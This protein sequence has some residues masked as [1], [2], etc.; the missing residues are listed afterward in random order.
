MNQN[1]AEKPFKYETYLNFDE[2][3][4]LWMGGIGFVCE[5][6]SSLLC[7]SDINERDGISTALAMMMGHYTTTYFPDHKIKAAI[8]V[9]A[10]KRHLCVD[11]E[12]DKLLPPERFLF[13]G[14]CN[15]GLFAMEQMHTGQCESIPGMKDIFPT[16][17][18]DAIAERAEKFLEKMS[19]ITLAACAELSDEE[20]QER[21]EG[22][23][24]RR[25]MNP[26]FP[27]LSNLSNERTLH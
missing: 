2:E 7:P 6:I 19:L 8:D 1:T 16:G 9:A 15:F 5:V 27:Q 3:K 20:L 4:F 21:I 14:G 22:A 24:A 13:N 12:T 25:A 18:G 10:T 17:M 23:L 11:P 26:Q